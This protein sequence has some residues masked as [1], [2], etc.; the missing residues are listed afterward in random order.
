M[1][2]FLCGKGAHSV[3]GLSGKVKEQ[4]FNGY[5]KCNCDSLFTY[6]RTVLCRDCRGTGK[7]KQRKGRIV[8]CRNC[9][10]R[11][12]VRIKGCPECRGTGQ[13]SS[14]KDVIVDCPKCGGLGEYELDL[15]NPVIPK[16]A[17]LI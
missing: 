17:I 11:G 8:T 2:Y 9:Q 14:Y 3:V 15:W 4:R 6:Y 12:V 7:F 10:G 16:G 5:T 13:R 1:I